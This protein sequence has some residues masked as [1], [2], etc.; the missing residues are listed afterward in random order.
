VQEGISLYKKIE[1][2]DV[3]E[4]PNNLRSRR[5]RSPLQ[6]YG[7]ETPKSEI[8]SLG[9]RKRGRPKTSDSNGHNRTTKGSP[10]KV[11]KK[12]K[13]SKIASNNTPRS[14]RKRGR[15][16]KTELLDSGNKVKVKRKVVRSKK[17][18]KENTITV[19]DLEWSPRAGFADPSMTYYCTIENDTPTTIARKVGVEWL[20]VANEAENSVR[21]PSLQNKRTRFRKGTLVRIP[22][23][24]KR[25][26]VNRLTE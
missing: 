19:E 3:F 16:R 6:R 8:L 9:K 15:P 17:M 21:F 10:N 13:V 22:I 7:C 26:N 25:A 11:R 2:S 14:A 18:K 4:N 12:V 23:G 5:R 1:D 20:D 24:Y